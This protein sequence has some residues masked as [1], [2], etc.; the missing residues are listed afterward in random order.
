MTTE[1]LLNLNDLLV[2]QSF[3]SG[4]YLVGQNEII[5]FAEQCDPSPSTLMTLRHITPS[6]RALQQVFGSR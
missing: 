5:D 1:V 2:C 4:E 6:S 3:H